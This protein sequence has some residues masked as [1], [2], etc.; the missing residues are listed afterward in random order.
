MVPDRDAPL[1]PTLAAC[2]PGLGIP[3]ATVAVVRSDNRRGAVA[4]ALA[5]LDAEIR[6]AAVGSAVVLPVLGRGRRDSADPGALSALL[7]LLLWVGLGPVAVASGHPEAARRFDRFGIARECWG[8][9]VSLVDLGRDEEDWE[10]LRLEGG[11]TLRLS[12][13]VTRS[14]FRV[15]LA[16]LSALGRGPSVF[17][18]P[19]EAV[20]P[21]DRPS[22]V[23]SVL[24]THA[25]PVLSVVEGPIGL[26]G[27]SVV[28]IAGLNPVAVDDTAA[29][30][31]EAGPRWPWRPDRRSRIGLGT[32]D[33]GGIAIVGDAVGPIRPTGTRTAPAPGIRVD[34]AHA[35]PGGEA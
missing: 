9:P 17:L 14:G 25:G 30:L 32:R 10:R 24:S 1:I 5:L 33:S 4:E 8:R 26:R 34:P 23:D 21:D 11:E 35:N 16:P 19:R 6:A 18:A 13:L 28:A 3:G 27:R 22:A 12:R 31:L 20:H 7:D 2:P 15:A 29:R